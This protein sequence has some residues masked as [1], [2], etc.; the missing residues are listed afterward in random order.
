[1]LEM[2]VTTEETRANPKPASPSKSGSDESHEFRILF[3]NL[4]VIAPTISFVVSYQDCLHDKWLPGQV[5]VH[6]FFI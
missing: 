1:M 3:S 6:P 2:S 4:I 5:F